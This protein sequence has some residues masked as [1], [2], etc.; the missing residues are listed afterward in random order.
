MD[1]LEEFIKLELDEGKRLSTALAMALATLSPNEAGE[2]ASEIPSGIQ[3]S[4]ADPS[5]SMPELMSKP[6]NVDEPSEKEEKKPDIPSY[7]RRQ[8]RK[9][10]RAAANKHGVSP[11]FVD[12]VVRTE[13]NYDPSVTSSK[14]AQGIMQ[15]MP[16]TAQW[17]GL[18][19]PW[20]AEKSIDAGTKYLRKLLDRYDD[21]YELAAAAYNAG[22]GNVEKYDGVP[23]FSETQ[24]Y[25]KKIKARMESSVFAEP[26][27]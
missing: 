15:I 14:G 11:A 2:K 18:E 3:Q 12:A 21:D 5:A 1:I 16:A 6:E 22:M 19:D 26:K 7:T 8:I 4:V 27:E 24:E 10:I 9:F 25:V 17:L 20:D 23:P 13:S